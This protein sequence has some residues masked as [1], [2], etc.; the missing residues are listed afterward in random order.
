[1]HRA[2]GLKRSWRVMAIGR[3]LGATL[4]FDVPPDS[5]VT[6]PEVGVTT[7]SGRTIVVA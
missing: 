6:G 2:K 7:A 1:M 3:D 5:V 4:K